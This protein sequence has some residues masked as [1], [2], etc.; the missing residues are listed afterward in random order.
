MVWYDQGLFFTLILNAI[1]LCILIPL[2]AYC[3]CSKRLSTARI[4]RPN[5]TTEPKESVF[6]KKNR[7]NE[8][9]LEGPPTG[10]AGTL[11][12]TKRPSTFTL[13]SLS[14][15][16]SVGEDAWESDLP[17]DPLRANPHSDL[18]LAFLKVCMLIFCIIPLVSTAWIIVLSA[19]DDY[20]AK[21]NVAADPVDCKGNNNAETDCKGTIWCEWIF[22]NETAGEGICYPIEING[23]FDLSIQNVTP[24]NFRNWIVGV[25]ALIFSVLFA[26]IM[27]MMTNSVSK[28]GKRVWTRQLLHAPGYRTVLV[29]GLKVPE[30]KKEGE[31]QDEETKDLPLFSLENFKKA[32][33]SATVY[34][35]NPKEDHV[36][37]GG[38]IIG[39]E[40]ITCDNTAL[41]AS[42]NAADGLAT[43]VT[44]VV[45]DREIPGDLEDLWN[46][47]I[48]CRNALQD[49]VAAERVFH[50]EMKHDRTKA[51]ALLRE[52]GQTIPEKW[53]TDTDLPPLMGRPLPA[54]CCA[55]PIVEHNKEKLREAVTA[56]NAEIAT[57]A[58]MGPTGSAFVTF[59]NAQSAFEFVELF[60]QKFGGLCSSA[61]AMIAGPYEDIEKPN[62]ARNKFLSAIFFVIF[63]IVFILLV[64]LWAIPVGFLGSL[65]NLTSLPGIGPA[66]GVL[67]R[68][69]P[70][71]I[72]GI[73]TAYLPVIVLAI[74]NIVLPMMIRFFVVMGGS[75][76]AMDTENGVMFQMYIFLVMTGVVIQAA[77]QGGLFQLAGVITDPTQEAIFALI[78]A[79]VSPQG[80]YWYAKVIGAGC[81]S[82]WLQAL[83]LGP[84]IISKILG[85]RSSTQRDYN[86]LYIHLPQR[87]DL[88]LAL[89]LTF[90]SIGMFFHVTVP[91]ITFF[92][93]IYFVNA[94]CVW[95]GILF[96]NYRPTYAP[97][98]M[99]SSF[100]ITCSCMRILSVLY[101]IAS[102][103]S[104]LVLALKKHNGGMALAIVAFVIGCLVFMYVFVRSSTW[105]L[106][107]VEVR[108]LIQKAEENT[109]EAPNSNNSKTNTS[110]LLSVPRREDATDE[111]NVS[112]NNSPDSSVNVSNGNPVV[113]SNNYGSAK[114]SNN[115]PAPMSLAEKEAEM[116]KQNSPDPNDRKTVQPYNSVL[117]Q[118]ETVDVEAVIEYA[119]DKKVYG[120]LPIWHDDEE[121]TEMRT[122]Y[123]EAREK[124]IEELVDDIPKEHEK[125]TKNNSAA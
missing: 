5:H 115:E 12:E 112:N 49:S 88:S 72:L 119:C 32:Y 41:F 124:A 36:N 91:F 110:P 9:L 102:A 21:N 122:A 59:E 50:R 97:C 25:F 90:A 39:K 93:G 38:C 105:R 35:P 42:Y 56:L 83:L 2:A 111:A 121:I 34:F 96:D 82:M 58:D 67:V 99:V 68:E 123:Q 16:L 29:K 19:T 84:I 44:D 108:T 76:T 31:A 116:E 66:F 17:T 30:V 74:F 55:V 10:V 109:L 125:E 22:T 14:R 43:T 15:L 62:L 46:D 100:S 3:I 95:R 106:N 107:V 60:N 73:I 40:E 85:K 98:K 13:P 47:Y 120:V 52:K 94:Y 27:V 23:L 101:L 69:I 33:L 18:L 11:D 104:I 61:V 114:A 24:E 87:F 77:L 6:E 103:G 57:I 53:T 65:E 118:L 92:V 37:I 89:I 80:G 45:F 86:G 81:L 7:T 117:L 51:Y 20:V 4:Y 70:P 1:A 8:E 79:I 64:F 54:V 75:M 63:T 28:Y 113:G 26:V 78:V 48:A 71:T